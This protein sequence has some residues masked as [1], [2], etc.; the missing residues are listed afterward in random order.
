MAMINDLI[1][2]GMNEL[3]RKWYST[4]MMPLHIRIDGEDKF[5]PVIEKI[6]SGKGKGSVVMKDGT[7]RKF[8]FMYREKKGSGEGYNYYIKLV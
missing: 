6:A 8:K 5:G 2:E 7:I 1:K 4:G 3:K